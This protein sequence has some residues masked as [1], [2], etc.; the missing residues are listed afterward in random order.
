[1]ANIV[2]QKRLIPEDKTPPKIQKDPYEL[3][4]GFDS[5]C[6]SKKSTGF[7]DTKH[8]HKKLSQALIKLTEFSKSNKV[9]ST[10]DLPGISAPC[11]Y[12]KWK[13]DELITHKFE[14]NKQNSVLVREEVDDQQRKLY[15][16]LLKAGDYHK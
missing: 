1:M 9:T 10:L 2:P 4:W 16:H 6:G 7:L 15:V 5:I 14:L 8:Y 11:Q 13:N 12:Q 3:F